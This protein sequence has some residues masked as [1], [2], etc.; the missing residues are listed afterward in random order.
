MLKNKVQN[1]KEHSVKTKVYLIVRN[2]HDMDLLKNETT[3]SLCG[4]HI[5]RCHPH[6]VAFCGDLVEE[7]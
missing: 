7:N 2:G 1:K 3:G 4:G 5:K 6:G